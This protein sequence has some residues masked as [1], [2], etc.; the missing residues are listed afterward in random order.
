MFKYKKLTT[1]V[2]LIVMAAMMNFMVGCESSSVNEPEIDN[3]IIGSS[4]LI[5]RNPIKLEDSFF[6][7]SN[8]YSQLLENGI[9]INIV[10]TTQLLNGDIK[11][12]FWYRDF[13][14]INQE[15]IAIV[16][17]N[18]TGV[19]LLSKDNKEIFNYKFTIFNENHINFTASTQT[20]NYQMNAENLSNEYI[21][22]INIDNNQ[23]IHTYSSVEEKERAIELYQSTLNESIVIELDDRE[24]ELINMMREYNELIQ[25]LGPS[26][27]QAEIVGQMMSSEELITWLY[28]GHYSSLESV[29]PDKLCAAAGLISTFGSYFLWSPWVWIIW[30]PATG[31]SI[32]CGISTLAK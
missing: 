24:L 18:L 12:S 11:L 19:T 28:Q 31:I 32:A 6:T 9:K 1:V 29:D 22:T 17:N 25:L 3:N 20:H 2:T 4:N 10:D 7:K 5:N 14:Y 13:N 16:N 26:N 21:E 23:L 30:A 15:L 27:S 8:I